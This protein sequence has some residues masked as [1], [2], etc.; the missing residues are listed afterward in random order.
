MGYPDPDR[1]TMMSSAHRFP[2]RLLGLLS[3]CVL[4]LIRTGPA[5][6]QTVIVDGN[7]TPIANKEGLTLGKGYQGRYCDHGAGPDWATNPGGRGGCAVLDS[8][9]GGAHFGPGG[10]GTR[11]DPVD[12]PDDFEVLHKWTTIDEPSAMEP[13]SRTR[14][15]IRNYLAGA[16]RRPDDWDR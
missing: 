8:G 4:L 12:F 10:R 3:G 9:G 1:E 7:T 11:D 15:Y 14:E 16:A 6:A 2:I 13:P 5:G